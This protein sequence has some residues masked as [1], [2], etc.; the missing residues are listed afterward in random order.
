MIDDNRRIRTKSTLPDEPQ[1]ISRFSIVLMAFTL[2]GMG[3]GSALPPHVGA[4]A[5]G[6]GLT[7]IVAYGAVLLVASRRK[8]ETVYSIRSKSE[9]RLVRHLKSSATEIP[10]LTGSSESRS[11]S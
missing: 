11:T 9:E 2:I 5:L 1:L 4:M 6:T 3:I 7:G 10:T 8:Q